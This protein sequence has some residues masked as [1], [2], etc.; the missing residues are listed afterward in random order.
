MSIILLI[1]AAI[2]NGM[3]ERAS[4]RES[5]GDILFFSLLGFIIMLIWINTLANR[6]RDYGSNP[7]YAWWSLIPFVN[8]GMALYYG[9]VPYKKNRN[10]Q[11]NDNSDTLLEDEIYEKVMLEIEEDKKVKSTW[12]KAFA[13][14]QGDENKAKALY[15]SLRVQ[16]IQLEQ[17]QY[18]AYL[19]D[20]KKQEKLKQLGGKE[21]T[22]QEKQFLK[23]YYVDMYSDNVEFTTNTIKI[24]LSDGTK[25]YQR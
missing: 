4:V 13:Q 18:Q 2:L 8:I 10:L 14:S 25:I 22:K 9:I 24:Y 16:E 7:K 11:G 15:I 20:K 17:K 19:K 23:K 3:I 5:K 12:A 21:L 6:I 1:P